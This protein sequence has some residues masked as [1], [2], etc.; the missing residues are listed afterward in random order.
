MGICNWCDC[1]TSKPKENMCCHE[2]AE[3]CRHYKLDNMCA[4]NNL[5]KSDYKK[6]CKH[7]KVN[8]T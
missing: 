3:P 5:T 2:C 6:K 7:Y 4:V 8:K 1:D